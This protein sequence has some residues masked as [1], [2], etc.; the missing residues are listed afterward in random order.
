MNKTTSTPA[1]ASA[2]SIRRLGFAA[3]VA[4]ALVPIIV[5]CDNKQGPTLPPAK[6]EGA[7]PGPAI[8]TLTALAAE[9]KVGMAAVV[10]RLGTGSLDALHK[11]ELGP[12]ESG[13]ITSITVDEGDRV[14][15]GQLLFKLDSAQSLLAVEQAKTAVTSAR[16]QYDAAK[17]DLDRT[18]ALRARNSISDDLLDQA[19]SRFD[20]AQSAVAQAVAAQAMAQRRASDSAVLSPIDGVVSE[21]RMSVGETATMMPPSIVLVVQDIDRLELRARLPE[22]ALRTVRE[23]SEIHVNFPALGEQRTLQVK[24]IAPTIDARTRTIEIV[25]EVA[26]P[27]H[28]LKAGMLAEVSYAK[29]SP[30][31]EQ[32]RPLAEEARAQ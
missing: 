26:N 32:P 18:T 30:P 14:K 25:A 5:A 22:T 8:P 24:R 21:K 20:A 9:S 19:K 2:L 29:D 27:D 6:G 16:V 4:A 15:K 1:R 31:S 12:K 10:D 17:L 3:L 11:A 13:V 7:P 23:K 28:R